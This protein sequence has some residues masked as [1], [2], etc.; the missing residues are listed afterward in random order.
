M[1]SSEI[2]EKLQGLRADI[3]VFA[4]DGIIPPKTSTRTAYVCNTDP[5]TKKGQHWIA[6]YIDEDDSG[7]FFDSYGLPPTQI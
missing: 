2:F 7:Y 6:I 1:I 5:H 4:K 3:G